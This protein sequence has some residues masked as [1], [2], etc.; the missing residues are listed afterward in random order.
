MTSSEPVIPT[1]TMPTR[2][3]GRHLPV[4]IQEEQKNNVPNNRT[5]DFVDPEGF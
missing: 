1:F 5:P 4:S 2:P 3:V